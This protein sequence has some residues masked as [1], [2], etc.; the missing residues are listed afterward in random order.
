MKFSTILLTASSLIAGASAA[1]PIVNEQVTSLF[2]SWKAEHGHS[3]NS[4]TEEEARYL[5]FIQNL[6]LITRHNE[7]FQR[8]EVSYDLALNAF[9]HMTGEEF[10]EHYVT[11]EIPNNRDVGAN[12]I[13]RAPKSNT[14]G[15]LGGAAESM[16][17]REQGAVTAVKNQG[18][19][20]SCWAFSAIGSIEGAH[21]L[22]TG[23][24]VELSEQ[25]ILRCAHGGHCSCQT[26]GWMEWAFKYVI[27]VGGVMSE[28]EEPY[29]EVRGIDRGQCRFKDSYDSYMTEDLIAATIKG[30]NLIEQ[31]DEV[32]LEDAVSQQPVSIAI[33][34]SNYSFQ[35]YNSGVYAPEEC[36]ANNQCTDYDLDHGVLAVGYGTDE[37]GVDYWIVKNSWGENW[38]QDG[39]INM[40]KG[41]GSRCGVATDAIY[42]LA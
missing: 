2:E 15:A 10:K 38:G 32:A 3:F 31:N 4:E 36:C 6:E 1:L 33:D 22:A 25:Q 8:G 16:D 14:R 5:T 7:K 21:F 9:A 40:I 37:N 35:F 39:Y 17:W 26:G 13:H 41:D 24:L 18:Q 11:Y 28:A 19:C 42:P 29:L 20:G 30:Y 12:G 34:A 27:K 23:E